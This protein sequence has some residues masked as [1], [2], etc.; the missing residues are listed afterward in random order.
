[1]RNI[2]DNNWK[3]GDSAFDESD[4]TFHFP[5]DG[6]WQ[7]DYKGTTYKCPPDR[8]LLLDGNYFY[9]YSS[10]STTKFKRKITITSIGS[11]SKKVE[12]KVIWIPSGS[13]SEIE[14][15]VTDILYSWADK[16]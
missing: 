12:S 15:N 1:M 3:E 4:N 6:C 16:K 9:E 5:H 2:R 10:G 14:M 11:D 8:Y 7:I 13:S